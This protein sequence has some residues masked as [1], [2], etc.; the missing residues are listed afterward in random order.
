MEDMV[1]A[2]HN[3]NTTKGEAT[4][5]PLC[6]NTKM[7]EG[8]GRDLSNKIIGSLD[9]LTRGQLLRVSKTVR[10]KALDPLLWTVVSTSHRV[11][12]PDGTVEGVGS[13]AVG[14]MLRGS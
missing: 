7:L 12:S 5:G 14:E 9:V 13:D 11:M 4:R 1:G 10:A 2:R 8:F 6:A 3:A